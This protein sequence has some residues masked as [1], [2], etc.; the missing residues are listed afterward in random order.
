MPRWVKSSDNKE[1][2]SPPGARGSPGAHKVQHP[3][4]L[5]VIFI[6]K[7]C[8]L[9]IVFMPLTT[10]Q[11]TSEHS[12]PGANPADGN[13]RR[14]LPYCEVLEFRS[15]H[16]SSQ[17]QGGS[18]TAATSVFT[19][20][21]C[22]PTSSVTQSATMPRKLSWEH[23]LNQKQTYAEELP[24]GTYGSPGAEKV[25]HPLGLCVLF[26]LKVCWLALFSMALMTG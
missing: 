12:L 15:L 7:V 5:C 25:Q 24:S 2:N 22:S 4:G 26:I 16:Q 17:L 13:V 8:R 14:K 20:S 18:R 3:L 6:F 10:K 1:E 21:I 23:S 19:Q 11:L 9:T